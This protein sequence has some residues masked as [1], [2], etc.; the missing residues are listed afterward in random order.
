[1]GVYANKT[2]SFMHKNMQK[3]E[4][5]YAEKYANKNEKCR[6]ICKIIRKFSLF[7]FIIQIFINQTDLCSGLCKCASLFIPVFSVLPGIFAK[8]VP[9]V[10]KMY[11]KNLKN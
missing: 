8:N 5:K 10:V 4:V 1:M 9:N 7:I 11:V 3:N 2:G 6:K